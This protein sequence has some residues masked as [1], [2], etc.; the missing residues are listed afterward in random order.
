MQFLQGKTKNQTEGASNA[1]KDPK[2]TM[3]AYVNVNTTVSKQFS[4][5]LLGDTGK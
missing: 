3:D 1:A 5:V 2:L 4:I